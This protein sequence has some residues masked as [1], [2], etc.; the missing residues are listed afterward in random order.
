MSD[1]VTLQIKSYSKED[2]KSKYCD[3]ILKNR[4]LLVETEGENESLIARFKIGDGVTP[5]KNLDYI[6]SIYKLLPNTCLYDKN[7]LHGVNL[8]FTSTDIGD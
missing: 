1:I 2:M 4:E 8:V 6:S 7:Y 5:Y 3:M